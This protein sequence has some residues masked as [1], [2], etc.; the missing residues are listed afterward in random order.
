VAKNYFS[1]DFSKKTK[2]QKKTK[3][4]IYTPLSKK[5]TFLLK[6]TKI[7]KEGGG[8]RAI[9]FPPL[10]SKFLVLDLDWMVLPE[11]EN[12]LARLTDFSDFFCRMFCFICF[13]LCLAC[14]LFSLFGFSGL[15]G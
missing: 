2:K 4:N 12:R 6:F 1:S 9:V 8:T 14:W 5:F 3:R 13:W 7:I 15:P 10:I 11:M